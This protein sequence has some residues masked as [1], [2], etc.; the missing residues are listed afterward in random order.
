M[1]GQVAPRVTR[2]PG[3]RLGAWR[4]RNALALTTRRLWGTSALPQENK[5]TWPVGGRES[6]PRPRD[7]RSPVSWTA[8][9]PGHPLRG[10]LRDGHVPIDQAFKMRPENLRG[11]GCAKS[12]GHRLSG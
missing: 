9:T 2:L 12:L 8:S 4:S 6:E 11:Q 3:V 5:V 7:S 10:T 1:G